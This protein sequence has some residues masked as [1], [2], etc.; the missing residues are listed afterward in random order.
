MMD[1]NIEKGNRAEKPDSLLGKEIKEDKKS[2]LKEEAKRIA[3]LTEAVTQAQKSE[4]GKYEKI[5]AEKEKLNRMFEEG[6]AS[7]VKELEEIQEREQS[8]EEKVAALEVAE[9]KGMSVN[10]T[11]FEGDPNPPYGVPVF[12][13][14][15]GDRLFLEADGYGIPV[16]FSRIEKVEFP[17]VN[18][19]TVK[20]ITEIIEM[21][22][23]E[24]QDYGIDRMYS[25]DQGV[26]LLDLVVEGEGGSRKVYDYARK[27]EFDTHKS[28]GTSMHVTEYDGSGDFIKY[29][30]HIAE[31]N[32]LT[33]KWQKV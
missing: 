22:G 29:P 19:P 11:T 15:D 27:G 13:E 5:Y 32:H 23:G 14:E 6:S 18:N 30:E 31:F 1:N 4:T 2:L 28:S 10:T 20:E 21:I 8:A 26:Y 24:S 17:E 9:L 25:D 16:D 3:Q 12:L 7:S 33:G